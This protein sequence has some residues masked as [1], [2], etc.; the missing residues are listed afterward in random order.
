MNVAITAN[1]SWYLYNFRKNTILSLLEQGYVVYAVAP[2][3]CYS[4]K[5]S[6]LGCKFVS[7]SI[8][9]GG[10][11]P[12]RDF[13]TI[14]QFISFYRKHDIKCVLNFTPKNNIYSTISASI[15]GVHSINN[16]AGLG[17]L[18][19]NETF[20]SKIARLL[21]KFSQKYA[22]KIFFQNEEDRQIF[23]DGGYADESITERL[24]G[25]G[26][27]LSRFKYSPSLDDGVVRFLLIARMLYDKG[28]KE[29]V[30]AARILRR[31]YGDKVQF[32]LLGFLDVKNPSAVYESEM[33]EW[34]S[35]EVITYLGTSDCVESE[36]SQVDC[37]V[38]PSFYR[39]GVPKSLLEAGAMGKPIV[40]TDNVGCRE[41][42]DHGVNGYL[43]EPR[44]VQSLVSALDRVI[45]LSHQDRLLMGIA[46]RKKM[47][48]EFDEKIVINK[49][50]DAVKHCLDKSR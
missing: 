8:D 17:V 18:F 47:E 26:V 20:S 37:M 40:T 45:N 11:N 24:P 38:L 44:S 25:S 46:S 19:V 33:D 4:T 41:T 2:K 6:E 22:Y 15:F 50:L 14:F 5:L 43:C 34:V 10:T 1:T 23:L 39:E 49:Y 13:K 36:I 27:D 32:S 21:Y 29:Y 7:V 35:E 12:I 30:E 28:I 16:I 42:V 3:D 9:Q 31:K 48:N